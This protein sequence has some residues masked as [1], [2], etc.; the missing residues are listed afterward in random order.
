MGQVRNSHLQPTTFQSSLCPESDGSLKL[1]ALLDSMEP[2]AD[3]VVTS[4]V[5]RLLFEAGTF[6]VAELRQTLE[7]P[8][9]EPSRRLSTQ[10]RSSRLQA[11]QTKLGSFR[12][13]GQY[14]PS[15]Q[16]VDLCSA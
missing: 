9:G 14:E 7:A 4:A 1:Q 10:E 6:V 8:T 5:H 16:L 11:L 12:I 13:A 15:F 2:K 3:P